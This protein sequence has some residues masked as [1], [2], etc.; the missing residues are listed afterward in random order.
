[1]Q[2]LARAIEVVHHAEA[3]RNR[4]YI[5]GDP[6]TLGYFVGSG[7]TPN[8]LAGPAWNAWWPGLAEF[9]SLEFRGS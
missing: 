9:A 3:V 4:E 5:G 2:Q 8:R 1:M 7:N 6:F